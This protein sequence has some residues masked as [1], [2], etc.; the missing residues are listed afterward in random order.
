MSPGRKRGAPAPE[1]RQKGQPTVKF[2]TDL[3]RDVMVRT[4]D[5]MVSFG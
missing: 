3:Y 4:L 2:G 1:L 5:K